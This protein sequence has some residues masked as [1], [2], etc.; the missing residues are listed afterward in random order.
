MY[1]FIGFRFLAD[2]VCSESHLKWK[3]EH[4]ADILCTDCD[5][6]HSDTRVYLILEILNIW[7][8]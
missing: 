8:K 7:Y 1:L 5:K 3:I 6:K 4:L 2:M